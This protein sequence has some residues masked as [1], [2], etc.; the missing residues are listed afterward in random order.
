MVEPAPCNLGTKYG[1][2][3]RVF[4]DDQGA[5]N[6]I[7]A[8]ARPRD[9]IR[10]RRPVR[11]PRTNRLQK[12]RAIRFC[13]SDRARRGSSTRA[14]P[15]REV[16]LI[17][18][19]NPHLLQGDVGSLGDQGPQERLVRT[20]LERCARTCGRAATVPV[21]AS[22]VIQRIAVAAST[23]KCMAACRREVA[24][25]AS[26]TGSRNPG[27]RVDPRGAPH[28]NCGMSQPKCPA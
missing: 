20:S 6:S 9:R 1:A 27:C 16:V 12:W 8:G 26:T 18:Q 15:D 11:S 28:R 14:R 5:R 21:V 13:T 10:W 4:Y 22:A 3:R 2:R 25:S 23:P 24:P 17:L 19:A 7:L